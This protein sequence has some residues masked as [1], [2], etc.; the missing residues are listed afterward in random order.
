MNKYAQK[1]T[2]LSKRIQLI[3]CADGEMLKHAALASDAIS[4]HLSF[5]DLMLLAI[6]IMNGGRSAFLGERQV[7]RDAANIQIYLGRKTY[8]PWRTSSS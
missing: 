6:D 4:W 5:E 1:A 7:S 3:E 2:G 8:D